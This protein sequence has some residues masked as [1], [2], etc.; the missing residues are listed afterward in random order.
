MSWVPVFGRTIAGASVEWRAEQ[1]KTDI[2]FLT[3]LFVDTEG[4][5]EHGVNLSRDAGT[6]LSYRRPEVI[7][8]QDRKGTSV[9]P[10]PTRF[11]HAVGIFGTRRHLAW[12]L[13]RHAVTSTRCGTCKGTGRSTV[14]HLSSLRPKI[15]TQVPRSHWEGRIQR[16]HGILHATSLSLRPVEAHQWKLVWPPCLNSGESPKRAMKEPAVYDM[17]NFHYKFRRLPVSH[18]TTCTTI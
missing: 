14:G 9:S 13:P 3:L 4:S 10:R 11:G 15:P 17:K 8:G 16:P 7:P 2:R 6:Q 1:E 5:S 12:I 18:R